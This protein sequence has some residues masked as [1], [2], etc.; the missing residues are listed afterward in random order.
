MK[1][2]FSAC[3]YASKERV[4]LQCGSAVVLLFTRSR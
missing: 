2:N 1:I 3:A 4:A